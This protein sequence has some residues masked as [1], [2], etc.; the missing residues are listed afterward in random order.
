MNYISIGKDLYLCK[1]R[2]NEKLSLWIIVNDLFFEFSLKERHIEIGK[3]SGFE[4]EK[5]N[6]EECYN[7]YFEKINMFHFVSLFRIRYKEIKKEY[8]PEV[9]TLYSKI[10][11]EDTSF[12]LYE[13]HNFLIGGQKWK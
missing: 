4:Y 10:S 6:L 13:L 11:K 8:L 5:E 2:L 1:N 12:Y 9:S 7:L 3:A